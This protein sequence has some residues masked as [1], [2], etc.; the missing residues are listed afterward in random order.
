MLTLDEPLDMAFAPSSGG[1]P[2][3]D[4]KSDKPYELNDTLI[5]SP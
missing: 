3:F 4:E 1:E 5:R 2:A